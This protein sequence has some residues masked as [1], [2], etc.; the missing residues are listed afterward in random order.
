MIITITEPGKYF[1]ATNDKPEIGRSYQLEDAE[2]G[3]GAQNRA[4]HSLLGVYYSSRAWSYEGSGYDL[5]ATYD[6][7]RNLVKRKLGAGFERF[8]YV[9]PNEELPVIHDA[10]ALADIPPHV[11]RNLIRGRLKS[12]S[13]YSKRERRDTMDRLIAE[14]MEVG[15]QSKKFFEILEGME[16]AFAEPKEKS[17]E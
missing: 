3:T 17:H 7:F 10:A 2:S 8:I 16:K 15:V 12:W 11:P 9:D 14:M 5:G 13:D 1:P 6:E 4:F